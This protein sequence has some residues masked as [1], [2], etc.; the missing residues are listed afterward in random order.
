M[1]RW[2]AEIQ[3]PREI[4]DPHTLARVICEVFQDVDRLGEA[5]ASG[6]L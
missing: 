2:L 1:R 3:P 5:G 6:V 4:D